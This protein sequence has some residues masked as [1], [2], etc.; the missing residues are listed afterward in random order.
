MAENPEQFNS[1]DKQN[2]IYAGYPENLK[3]DLIADDI[4]FDI[5]SDD[6]SSQE[7]LLDSLID[8]ISNSDESQ[9]QLL[10]NMW[11]EFK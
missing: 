3:L 5:I 7:E 6:T 11:R 10:K 1:I 2:L 4:K 8:S 9:K